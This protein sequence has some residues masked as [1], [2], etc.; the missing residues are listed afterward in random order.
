MSDSLYAAT[1]AKQGGAF[2]R[3]LPPQWTDRAG[4]NRRLPQTTRGGRTGPGAGETNGCAPHQFKVVKTLVDLRALK[5]E[6]DVLFSQSGRPGQV[7]QTHAWCQTWTET[8]LSEQGGSSSLFILTA[9]QGDRLVMVWPLAKEHSAGLTRLVWLG[10]PV[11]QYGDVLVDHNEDV[12]ALLT[13]VWSFIKDEAD[14][15]YI[16]L[17]K[18]REDAILHR[19]MQSSGALRTL[20]EGAPQLD[21]SQASDYEGYAQKFSTKSRKTRQ[22][23]MR[24]LAKV[25]EVTIDRHHGGEAARETVRE[26][27]AMKRIWLQATGRVSKAIMDPRTEAFFLAICDEAVAQ[28]AGTLVTAMRVDGKLA[29]AEICFSCKGQLVVH[30]LVYELE[31]EKFSAGQN[32]LEHSIAAC[33]ENEITCF[34]LMAPADSYKLA[35]ADKSLEVTDWC[36]PLTFAGRCWVVGYLGLVRENLK[37]AQAA[38]PLSVRRFLAG[39]HCRLTAQRAP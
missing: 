25:G 1:N 30:V 8:F 19:F 18:V 32:L 5:S 6:W 28:E 35:W 29:A 9:R 38:T 34:D 3:L 14:V 16:Q 13:K 31:F 20:V 2:G 15:A 11:T 17:A 27:L 39:V 10:S 22:R 33:F 24:K 21:L 4:I 37:R 7:F 12:G 26:A 36:Q 23:K